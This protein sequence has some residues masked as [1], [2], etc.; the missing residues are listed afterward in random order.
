MSDLIGS[1]VFVLAVPFQRDE[2]GKALSIAYG[3]YRLDS[4]LKFFKKSGIRETL[5]VHSSG[6]VIAHSDPRIVLARGNLLNLKIV[7]YMLRSPIDNGQMRYASAGQ[8][9][10]GSFKKIA[11]AGLGVVVSAPES[12]AFEVVFNIQRRNIY[13]TLFVLILATVVVYFFAKSLSVPLVH[14]VDATAEVEKGRFDVE[15]K[16]DSGDEIGILTRSF[17]AMTTGLKERERLKSTL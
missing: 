8:Y 2:G 10:L 15:V 17:N 1:P 7:E 9:Y 11:V 16:N 13:F 6:E 14:L 5:I 3:F 4:F 12:K